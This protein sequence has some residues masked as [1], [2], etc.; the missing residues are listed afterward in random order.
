MWLD[1]INYIVK[2]EEKNVNQCSYNV[3][4]INTKWRKDLLGIYVSKS[5]RA[6][7]RLSVLTNLQ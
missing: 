6:N 3:F 7:F 1:F 5:E 4:D 2:D